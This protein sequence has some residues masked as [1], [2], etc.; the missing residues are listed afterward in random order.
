MQRLFPNGGADEKP[1]IFYFFGLMGNI[2]YNV[3]LYMTILDQRFS[4]L[5]AKHGERS[6]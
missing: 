3:P 4:I 1:G 5:A 6:S 2:L